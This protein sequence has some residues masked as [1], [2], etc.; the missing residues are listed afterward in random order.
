MMDLIAKKTFAYIDQDKPAFVR[1]TLKKVLWLWT[2]V[3]REL[4]RSTGD[5][6]AV[7]Y[8][9]IHSGYWF[10]FLAGFFGCLLLGMLRKF[11]IILSFTTVVVIYSIVYG[12]TIVGNA[13]FRAVIEFLFI[14]VFAAACVALY[15]LVFGKHRS[16]EP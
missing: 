16:T 1:R 3:P 4:L 8:Y 6:E 15:E 10:L 11:E 14:P 13:R 12:L 9:W 2:A 5:S 7:K